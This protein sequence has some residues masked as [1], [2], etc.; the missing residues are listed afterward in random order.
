[1]IALSKLD[2]SPILISLDTIKYIESTPDSLIFFVNGDSI[3]VRESLE[4]IEQRVVEYK[5]KVLGNSPANPQ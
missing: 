3:M 1:M 5:M 2:K 4:E